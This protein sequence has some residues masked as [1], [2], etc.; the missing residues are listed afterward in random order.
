PLVSGLATSSF[1]NLPAGTDS[2]TATYSGDAN[3][4][5]ATSSIL[6]IT[7]TPSSACSAPTSAGVHVCAPVAGGTYSSPV[8]ITATGR[9]A[10]GTVNHME[11][12]IDG[13]KKGQYS[14]NSVNT[15]LAVAAG[16]HRVVV[17]EVD[18]KGA[19]QKS[20][21]VNFTIGTSSGCSAPSSPGVK[22]CSPVAGSTYSSPV[23]ISAVATG[24]SGSVSRMELWID[25]KKISN[26][27]GASINTSVS[28]VATGSHHVTVVEVDSKGAVLKS[29][30]V[31]F[32]VK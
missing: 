5:G 28:S 2:I 7:I 25:G 8:Q 6:T 14:G 1:T 23:K 9:G 20:A 4:Q 13:V 3:Y 30:Q 31:P 18:S 10:S 16:A 29:P 19:F 26:Y 21:S 17:V 15:A 27:T 12:W 24:A 32:T 22:V 11:V